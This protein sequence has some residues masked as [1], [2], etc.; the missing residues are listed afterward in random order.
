[1]NIMIKMSIVLLAVSLVLVIF[2]HYMNHFLVVDQELVQADAIVVM[3]GDALGRIPEVADVYKAGYAH[4]VIMVE[5]ADFNEIADAKQDAINLGIPEENLIILL[6]EANSTWEEAEIVCAYLAERKDIN[7]LILINSDLHTRRSLITFKRVL[8][9]LDRDIQ[10]IS[11]ASRYVKVEQESHLR[12][13][14]EVQ[15]W[16]DRQSFSSLMIASAKYIYYLP[17]VIFY[18]GCCHCD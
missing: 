11:R 14:Y 15:W 6:G 12:E 8:G 16:Q 9:C 1:M 3:M 17:R 2:S 10:L 18:R 7:S 5:G 4:K 13:A